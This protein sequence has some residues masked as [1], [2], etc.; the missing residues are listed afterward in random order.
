MSQEL[1]G[2][3]VTGQM[4]KRDS[5]QKNGR[6]FRYILKEKNV[7]QILSV[8]DFT[9]PLKSTMLKENFS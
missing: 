9:V 6:N 2:L 1:R 7:K 5:P 4:V 8:R 3:E